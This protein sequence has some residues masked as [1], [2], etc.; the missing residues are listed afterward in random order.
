MTSDDPKKIVKKIKE[1]YKNENIEDRSSRWVLG[2]IKY[3]YDFG[4]IIATGALD[5]K[6]A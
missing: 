5:E 2:T 3:Q 6:R 4:S 1:K